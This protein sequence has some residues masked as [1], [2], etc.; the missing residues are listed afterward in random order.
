MNF[1]HEEENGYPY[2][3]SRVN[4]FD[5]DY[6]R[7]TPPQREDNRKREPSPYSSH[8]PAFISP[9]PQVSNVGC[10]LNLSSP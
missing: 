8:R 7:Q 1:S 3:K 6:H 4:G 2:A 10:D 9:S 5:S